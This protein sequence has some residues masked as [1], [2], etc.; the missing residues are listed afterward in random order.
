MT[1]E[2][3]WQELAKIHRLLKQMTATT[4]Q[5]KPFF[6]GDTQTYKFWHI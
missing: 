6:L 1:F 3:G 2:K 5:D 4:G